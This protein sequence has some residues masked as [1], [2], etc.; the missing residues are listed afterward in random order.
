MKSLP[1]TFLSGGFSLD[2]Q[3]PHKQTGVVYFQQLRLSL[4]LV[5]L[6]LIV[7]L[8]T[9]AQE[10]FS[11]TFAGDPCGPLTASFS[12]TV[13][14]NRT[15]TSYLWD[16]GNGNTSTLE[17]PSASYVTANSYTVS[18]TITYSDGTRE[19]TK[20]DFIEIFPSPTV[21]FI[22]DIQGGCTP[23]EVSF[24][25]NSTAPAGASITT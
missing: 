7:S 9:W 18:L 15:V 3:N 22:S 19:V 13:D 17:S 4:K 16:F 5:G 25:D 6:C 24:T 12:P 10:D 21:N 20:A 2:L 23:L 1:M 11:A 14:A 8:P